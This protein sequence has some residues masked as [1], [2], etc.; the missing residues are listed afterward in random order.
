MPALD[1]GEPVPP[2]LAPVLAPAAAL[3]AALSATVTAA[4]ARGVGAA[5]KD[6]EIEL[7]NIDAMPLAAL[8][9]EQP[10]P[11]GA[12]AET[13]EAAAPGMSIG[14]TIGKYRIE[15]AL[16]SGGAA[17][18][19]VARQV[20]AAGFDRRVAIKRLLDTH[21]DDKRYRAMLQHE[22]QL[23]ARLSHRNIA[24]VL[25]VLEQDGSLFLVME[26]I[27][28]Q[29]LREAL[30]LARSKGVAV[31]SASL[32]CYVGAEVAEA[33]AYA[34]AATDADGRRLGV[35]HRDVTPHNVMLSAS[36]DV[37]LIDFGI[38]ISGLEG[39][40]KTDVRLLK[41]KYSYMSPEQ[42]NEQELDGRSDLY[43]LGLVLTEALT[44]QRIFE[45]PSEAGT[46]RRAAE[47]KP[48]DIE[49]GIHG[50]PRDLRAILTKV[51]RRDR[52][53]RFQAGD[54]LAKAL[55]GY[56][57]KTAPG[58]GSSDVVAELKKLQQMP[59]KPGTGTPD[60]AAGHSGVES[61]IGS[62]ERHHNEV[63]EL[64]RNP[65]SP[66]RKLAL[67][68]VLIAGLVLL[69]NTLVFLVSK[70]NA[71]KTARNIELVQ[72]PE[73]R[74][75]EAEAEAKR[76]EATQRPPELLAVAPPVAAPA[77]EP[78]TAPAVQ[79]GVQSGVQPPRA[80]SSPAKSPAGGAPLRR[81]H[82]RASQTA[83]INAPAVHHRS[84]D[85]SMQTTFADAKPMAPG[86]GA[87]QRGTLIPARLTTPADPNLTGPVGA[88]VSD[89][90]SV[91]GAV[92]IP[93]GATLVC[94]SNG[95]R[96]GRVMV[97]CDGITVPGRGTSTFEGTALG[98]DELPGIPVKTTGGGS[99]DDSVKSGAISTAAN[100]AE[101]LSPGGV[102]GA[103][104]GGA[105]DTA[106]ERGRRAAAP[107]KETTTPAPK[108][109]HFF[110]FVAKPFSPP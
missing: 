90:V 73:Q 96:P 7:G 58:F 10:A 28:G 106:S 12:T 62:K 5:D 26:Y 27:E 69:G 38:A 68:I 19:Y 80:P 45:V 52:G 13:A 76:L 65:A 11:Q 32:V 93:K 25:D 30:E 48:E 66:K 46:L 99:D 87:I 74:R 95:G 9:A 60:G 78:G 85:S 70:T 55:R 24:H 59:D 22:A 17:V 21:L 44:G 43:S 18:V 77:V 75:A 63:R 16:S 67:P 54:E 2:E 72:T 107:A 104:V 39:R 8:M 108:R 71:P 50:L 64:L 35:V 49:A 33:L 57:A 79:S 105:V 29:S 41:G 36:G 84:L 14:A 61:S 3:K 15:S 31:L 40:E 88:I 37:K 34:H 86:S 23:A 6:V 1:P 51:F 94:T 101:A 109:T 4:I 42:A 97:A 83:A 102:G 81:G 98:S 100:V 47:A 56:L 20:G 110:I 91:N 82:A 53:E 89:D 103:L 92:V